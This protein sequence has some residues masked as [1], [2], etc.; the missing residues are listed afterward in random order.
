MP[1]KI[2]LA[3][4]FRQLP[5]AGQHSG[6]R[7]RLPLGAD[8]Q[9]GRG[10]RFPRQMGG[11]SRIRCAGHAIVKAHHTFDDAAAACRDVLRQSSAA[12][13]SIDEKQIQ[14][15]AGQ[16]QNCSMEHWVNII[17]GALE[18]RQRNAPP[19]PGTQQRTGYGRLA[20]PTARAADQ[21]GAL[22]VCSS[23]GPPFVSKCSQ[24]RIRCRAYR[25]DVLLGM[26]DIDEGGFKLAGAR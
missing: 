16:S 24:N 6:Q 3:A 11:R 19:L 2:T 9:H 17:C 21:A 25:K 12:S 10:P 23:C 13:C 8:N 5:Q 1:L 15:A 4:Y 7:Q 22:F 20:A 18:R 14:I 26:A